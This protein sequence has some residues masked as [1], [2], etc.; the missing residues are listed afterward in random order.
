M[1]RSHKAAPTVTGPRCVHN[2]VLSGDV[3][4]AIEKMTI[5]MLDSA[6]EHGGS[7]HSYVELP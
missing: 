4:I 7:F 5:E 2:D 6:I 3:K 1:S